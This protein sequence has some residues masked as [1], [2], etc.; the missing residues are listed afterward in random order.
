M[1]N[2]YILVCKEYPICVT[3]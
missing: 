3:V 1:S 2:L